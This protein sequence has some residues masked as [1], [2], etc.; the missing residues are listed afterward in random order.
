MTLVLPEVAGAG[1]AATAHAETVGGA[2]VHDN[3][4]VVDSDCQ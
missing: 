4:A 1:S 3:V 2:C